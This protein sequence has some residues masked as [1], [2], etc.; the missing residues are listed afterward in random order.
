VSSQEVVPLQSVSDLITPGEPLPFRVLDRFGR[1]LLAQGQRVMD[2]QQLKSLLE[3]GASVV[4][5]EAELVRE[6]RQRAGGSSSR[7][8]S[9]RRLTWFDRWERHLWEIDDALREVVRGGASLGQLTALVDQQW[10]LVSGQPDAALFTIQRQDER[11]YALYALTH[12]RDAATVV[13]LTGGLLGWPDEKLHGAVAAALT[14]NASTVELQARMAEQTDAPSKKQIEQLREHPQRSA[15]L[16]RAAGVTDMAWLMA[17]LQHHEQAGGGGYPAGL[18][19]PTDI[20]RL[21]RAADVYT[22]KISPRAIRA[23]L[24][25]QTAAR[26]LFQEEKGS[27]LAGA[28]IKAMGVYPPGDL[29]TLTSGEVAIV[30]QRARGAAAAQVAVLLGSN[31]RPVGGGP[32]RDTGDKAFAISGPLADRSAVAR[33]LPEQVY[34]LLYAGDG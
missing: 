17:V 5:T 27:A 32:R 3:R 12:A 10:M 7:A 31:G 21:L 20:A 11:R 8:P 34:G 22:A 2:V 19:D 16:L 26:Q 6:E 9:G 4:Q 29:V 13:Q 33:V 30:V 15:D 25:S 14:M 24:P 23:A 28:L 1:L 18:E